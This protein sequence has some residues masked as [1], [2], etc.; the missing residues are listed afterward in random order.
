MDNVNNKKEKKT[1]RKNSYLIS[2]IVINLRLILFGARLIG[3]SLSSVQSKSALAKQQDNNSLAI[4]EVSSILSKN[5]SNAESLTDIYHDGNWKTLEDIERI[6]SNGLFEK[7]LVNDDSI[8]AEIFDGLSDSAGVAYLYVMDKEGNIV[9]CS[10]ESLIGRNPSSSNIMT[11]ENL[12]KILEGS[13][14]VTEAGQNDSV[15]EPVLVKNQFGTYYFYGKPYVHSGTV[16]VLVTGT[17]CWVLDE[18]ISSLSDVSTTLS[19]MGVVNDGFLF[20][21]NKN[22]KLFLHYK[23]G[24][25]FLTGQ[26]AFTTGLTEE[27]L[28][29]GYQ[30]L[31]TI[32]GEKYYCTSKVLDDRTVIVAAARTRDV[33]SHEK[34]V[35]M[36]PI[37]GFLLVMILCVVYAVIVSND[38]ARQGVQPEKVEMIGESQ[39][40]IYFNKSIFK[41]VLPLMLLGVI[42]VFGISFYTQTLVEITEGVDK[43]TV[44]LQEI[45]GRYEE[46][47]ESETVIEEYNNTRF[48]S[49]A[50]LVEFFVEETPEIF[51]EASD[52]YHST[53]DEDG[54]RVF[55]LDDEGNPLKSVAN[56]V[57]LQTICEDN[58][59]DAIYMFD[60]DGH[61]IATSTANWF[62]NISHNPED[63]S[64]PFLQVLDGKLDSYMQTSMVN[65]LGEENQYFGVVMHYYTTKD[66]DGNTV[67]VSRYTY[68]EACAAAG[69]SDNV[70]TV[71][72]ITRH[73]SLLQIELNE[74][75]V[76]SIMLSTNPEYVLSTRMLSGGAIVMF[77]TSRDHVCVYSPVKASIGKTAEELGVSPKAFNGDVYYGFSRVNGV[78]Y[79]QY[80]RYIDDYF[81]ATAI[82]RST[83]FTSRMTISLITAGICLVMITILMLT[84]ILTS[85]EEEK[86]YEEMIN[87]Y[88]DDDLNSSI[89]NI[90]LPSG[91]QASTTKAVVRWD[92][93]RIPWN[94]RSPE[95]K[96]GIILGAISFIVIVYFALTAWRINRISEND[97]VIRYIFSGNWDRSPNIFSM[98]ACFMV[99]IMTVIIIEVFKVPI[100]LCTTLLGTRGETI[101]HLLLSLVKYGGTI[102]S[103]FYCMYLLGI[104]SGNLLAS[105]GILSL[106][107][108]LGSQSLIKDILAGIFIVF[109]GEFRVGDIV[110]INGFRGRVTDIGLRT[111]KISG[112]GNV[113]IFNNSEISGV[114]NMTKETSVAMANIGLEYGQ[115]FEYVESVLAR[116][117]PLLKEDNKQILDGPTSLGITDMQERR[118]V[119]TIMARCSE[120]YIREVNRYLNKELLKIMY[121]NGIRVAN[122][123]NTLAGARKIDEVK[124]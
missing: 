90:I 74:S 44:I 100:R 51:N 59:I 60:E 110:T 16:Y 77:D 122:Q 115:D 108:G 23:N 14:A 80:Y 102:F 103:L 5:A 87:D 105:A 78:S 99:L 61:T 97:E 88:K 79:F 42:V 123:N 124:K 22:D 114:L 93:R 84:I 18:S 4:S 116:E 27:I 20:A 86:L 41:K 109:E 3:I 50:R 43:S 57:I 10:D 120:Q 81:I 17:S 69:V 91:R 118:Y 8:R 32:L 98:S 25:D 92:N 106:V 73:R 13:L 12:N 83:M 35:L 46:T 54:N 30:G 96:L 55:L 67:Y 21:I 31:Q 70:R 68:E 36:G 76:E 48:I 53:Y 37:L 33:V 62:F 72:G 82:P 2:K 101:G 117:L 45:N 104:D 94:E 11:Q 63:Q 6:F 24:S 64:Y 47:L 9:M 71:N 15:F 89:F 26:N 66:A 34:F 121:D 75:L 1:I 112:E 19:R 40:P 29:D 7:I 107:I 95:M 113:K 119:I 52:F 85:K 58:R 39:N 28:E 65:D 111:T 56:S 49:T 38:F